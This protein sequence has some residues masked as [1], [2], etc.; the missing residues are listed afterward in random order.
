MKK[1]F[2][3]AL[4]LFS[5]TFVSALDFSIDM[6]TK[7]IV[8]DFNNEI[9][10]DLRVNDAEKGSYN[11]YTLSDLLIEPSSSFFI[12]EDP[13]EKEF[14]LRPTSSLD[15]EGFYTF[16]ATLNQRSA[17]KT[18]KKV[19]IEIVNLEEIIEIESNTIDVENGD[20]KILI[21]NNVDVTIKNVTARF[22]SL[23]FDVE[24]TFDIEALKT[25]EI[26]IEVEESKLEKTKAGTYIIESEF[27]TPKGSKVIDGNLYLGEKKGITTQEDQSGLIIRSH[28]ITKINSGNVPTSV[29][30]VIKRGIFSRLFSS[31]SME[32]TS[33]E[34]KG[35]AIEYTWRKSKLGPAEIFS[36]KAKTNYL[37]P[38]LIIILAVVVIF[39]LRRFV[40]TRVEIKKSVTHVKTK[41]GEF[42]LKVRLSIKAKTDLENLSLV[43]RVPSI[44]KIY[45]K[46]GTV[47]PDEIDTAT[48]RIKWNV[49]DL[50]AGEER[51][52][53]YVI[54]SKVGVLGKFSMPAATAIFEKDGKILEAESNHVFFLS[55]QVRRD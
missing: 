37:F 54:Y 6:D 7:T 8:K 45:K 23:L 49:G 28:T 18:T 51:I 15:V 44:V 42:A 14:I 47:K 31:F 16:S 53:S 22:S 33:V 10:L 5:L 30:I 3:L 25:I 32:P 11:F 21:T 9:N 13:F 19:T 50:E 2:F 27:E 55:D 46:F 4:A 43:D 36:V 38:L 48:R 12:D 1:L 35:I 40:Q 41:H 20:V 39:G 52:F 26:P 34:R 24:K 17:E 29:E